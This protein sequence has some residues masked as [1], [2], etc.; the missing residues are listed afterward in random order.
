MVGRALPQLGERA[1]SREAFG[2]ELA[3]KDLVRAAVAESRMEI[4]QARLLTMHAARLI[5]T[6]G[7]KGARQA[8]AMIK[9]VAARVARAAAADRAIQAHGGA[10]VCQTTPLAQAQRRA[11]AAAR[12]RAGRGASAASRQD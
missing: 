9:V 5:D 3:R 12:G 7:G 11:H 2:S 4:T 8:I 1:A 10:G 6:R